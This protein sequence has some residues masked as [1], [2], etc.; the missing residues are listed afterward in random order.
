MKVQCS[1]CPAFIDFGELENNGSAIFKSGKGM[2]QALMELYKA[3]WHLSSGKGDI[4][5]CQK[6]AKKISKKEKELE[7][8]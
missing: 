1:K 2:K 8:V 4:T 6:C 5:L 3:G 7:K